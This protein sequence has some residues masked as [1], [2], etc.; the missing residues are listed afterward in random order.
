[1]PLFFVIACEHVACFTWD[2]TL[3]TWNYPNFI[4]RTTPRADSWLI[5]APTGIIVTIHFVDF[6]LEDAQ[7]LKDYL[8]IY[9]GNSVSDPRIG[10]DK[11]CHSFSPQCQETSSNNLLVTLTSDTWT[12]YRGFVAKFY[13]GG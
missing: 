5:T 10:D 1:M 7:C 4:H 12:F 6:R 9:D 8:I 13:L 3:T 2:G 11:Y